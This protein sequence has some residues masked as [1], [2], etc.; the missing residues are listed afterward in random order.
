GR[1]RSWIQ[2]DL[3]R[4]LYIRFPHGRNTGRNHFHIDEWRIGV[5]PR[6][7]LTFG[8]KKFIDD[9]RV[10]F[11]SGPP[12]SARGLASPD[13]CSR[14]HRSQSRSIGKHDPAT[15][16]NFLWIDGTMA[17]P[18]AQTRRRFV[19]AGVTIRA[20]SAAGPVNRNTRQ[21]R[22]IAGKTVIDQG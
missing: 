8:L 18:Q 7:S 16:R 11:V 4:V 21:E 3:L 15:I 20:A 6:Q 19:L 22:I 13:G 12:R 9:D 17:L 10:A 14:V 1:R 2:R 5:S